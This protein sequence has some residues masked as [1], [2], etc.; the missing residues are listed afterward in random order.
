MQLVTSDYSQNLHYPVHQVAAALS[1]SSSL[2]S[3]PSV[4][5]SAPVSS[6]VSPVIIPPN[7]SHVPAPQPNAYPL[8]PYSYS[9]GSPQ[10]PQQPVIEV[11]QLLVSQDRGEVRHLGQWSGGQNV[12]P[13]QGRCQQDLRCVPAEELHQPGMDSMWKQDFSQGLQ[14]PGGQ[15]PQVQGP[16]RRQVQVSSSQQVPRQSS[17]GSGSS[18]NLDSLLKLTITNPQYRPADFCKISSF[19]YA[20]ELNEKNLNLS[21][22]SYGAVKH[23]LALSDVYFKSRI[24]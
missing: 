20:K 18:S 16:S 14:C 6:T 1:S 9:G 21:L 13:S 17:G 5:I 22:F 11:K 3:A 15:L 7:C 19:P 24:S 10:L 4:S 12:Q 8:P 2:P 23:L